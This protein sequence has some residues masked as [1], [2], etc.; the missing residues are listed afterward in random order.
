MFLRTAV[1]IEGLRLDGDLH[2]GGVRVAPVALEHGFAGRE[3]REP[4]NSLLAE[5]G[6]VSAFGRP[7]WAAQIG[8]RRRLSLAVAPAIEVPEIVGT[9]QEASSRLAKL[10]DA[11]SVTHGGA[12]RVFAEVHEQS[13][14]GNTWRP[15]ALMVG[16]G[17]RPGS[18]L[19]RVLPENDRLMPIEPL[20]LWTRA[21]AD[22]LVSLW[23]SLYREITGEQQWD[24]RILR[25][26]SLLEAIGRERLHP[27]AAVRDVA[28]RRLLD[29]QGKPATTKSLRG[30]MYT[31]VS[32]AVGS[33][34]TSPGA[35]LC[36]DSRDLWDEVGVWADVR[37][38]VAHE[39]RWKPP[40]L[41]STLPAA[42]RRSAG[43]FELAG[44]GDDLE[45]GWLRYADAVCA[46]TEA[47]LRA[48]ALEPST[49][50]HT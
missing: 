31:L 23:Q 32:S 44:R 5:H 21:M 41:P 16:G 30:K 42:Q 15:F 18:V 14:D 7:I 17:T 24:V 12:P 37:N 43:A 33:V 40:A 13:G 46:G 25:C 50:A 27:M 35:L 8:P 47:V 6:F 39:G 9:S 26:C 22:P 29:E 28:G 45:A 2:V 49:P 38:M 48:I 1:L 4:L 11:L 36:H 10:V 19:E 34:I 20:D 3:L